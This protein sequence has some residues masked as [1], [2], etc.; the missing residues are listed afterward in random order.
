M[1]YEC[2]NEYRLYLIEERKDL[3]LPWADLSH[4]VTEAKLRERM[5][6][7]PL[8]CIRDHTGVP[9]ITRSCAA[10]LRAWNGV[11]TMYANFLFSETGLGHVASGVPWWSYAS[12]R[13]E[14][15][16]SLGHPQVTQLQPRAGV[17][18]HGWQLPG[19]STLF[20]NADLPKNPFEPNSVQWR[21]ANSCNGNPC[22]TP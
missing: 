8:R 10:Y 17:R 18:L 4:L 7:I 21:S 9:G 16:N 11:P 19:G 1:Q 2:R 15:K 3:N 13:K 14:L 22:I 6:P 5:H 20:F 12:A